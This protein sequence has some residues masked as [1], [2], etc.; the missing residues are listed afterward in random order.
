MGREHNVN[1]TTI[2]RV[3]VCVCV[4]EHC[5]KLLSHVRRRFPDTFA[6]SRKLWREEAMRKHRLQARGNMYYVMT[7]SL[8]EKTPDNGRKE[9][10]FLTAARER[11]FC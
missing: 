2:T 1:S 10:A 9:E 7:W 5:K 4:S 11:D 6:I 8:A 3:C